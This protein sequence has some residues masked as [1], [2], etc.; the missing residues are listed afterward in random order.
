MGKI[1]T[2]RDCNLVVNG[3]GPLI[4]AQRIIFS[5]A[6]FLP[7]NFRTFPVLSGKFYVFSSEN[8]RKAPENI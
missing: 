6:V 1:Q 8:A 4:Y 5:G 2:V 3:F 7:E